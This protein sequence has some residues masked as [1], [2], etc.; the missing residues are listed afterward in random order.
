MSPAEISQRIETALPGATV[1]VASDDGVH[2]SALVVAA[3]FEGLRAIARHQLVYRAL[4]ETMGGA[5]HAL[6]LDTPTPAE[7]AK[8]AAG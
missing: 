1:R 2:F 4:G 7:W 5:I 8:R 6:S 3:Q